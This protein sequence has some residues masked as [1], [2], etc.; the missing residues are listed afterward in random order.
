ME[1][2]GAPF[3]GQAVTMPI[4]R[5]VGRRE[6]GLG[7]NHTQTD[8]RPE[9]EP[10]PALCLRYGRFYSR[11]R[12]AIC[13]QGIDC[14]KYG[15]TAV[16]HRDFYGQF[17]PTMGRQVCHVLRVFGH[18]FAPKT[19]ILLLNSAEYSTNLSPFGVLN[20][21]EKQCTLFF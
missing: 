16:K 13:V 19:Q 10:T 18:I 5:G 6:A 7:D 2:V 14:C 15:S 1:R 9:I 11:R 12:P 17:R 8:V 21:E 20:T 3:R 4:V